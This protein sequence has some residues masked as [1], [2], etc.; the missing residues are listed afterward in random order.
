MR[1]VKDLLDI[2][3]IP[4]PDTSDSDG[5]HDAFKLMDYYTVAIHDRMTE[6]RP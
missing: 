2:S 4:I 1:R 3:S 5:E 6:V